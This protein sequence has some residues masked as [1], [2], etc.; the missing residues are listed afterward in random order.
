MSSLIYSGELLA[1]KQRI[2]KESTNGMYRHYPQQLRGG[3]LNNKRPRRHRTR[4]SLSP[5]SDAGSPL[6]AVNPYAE[7]RGKYVAC[8]KLPEYNKVISRPST[9]GSLVKEQPR[10]YPKANVKAVPEVKTV[11]VPKMRPMA[12]EE[13]PRR[14][15]PPKPELPQ[16]KE[17]MEEN[18]EEVFD[19]EDQE[20]LEDEVEE[21]PEDIVSQYSFKTTSSKLKYIEE[22]EELLRTER[23]KRIK[24]EAEIHKLKQ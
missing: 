17:E 14:L 2:S 22:L 16:V 7:V 8:A 24:L 5:I 18:P 23:A 20:E 13:G 1:W 11:G 19:E 12:Q 9:Q 6:R 3:I 15:P 21:L 4:H 10:S